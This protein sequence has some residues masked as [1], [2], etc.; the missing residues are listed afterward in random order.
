[1]PEGAATPDFEAVYNVILFYQKNPDFT[2]QCAL[3][4]N[5]VGQSVGRLRSAELM[6]PL[7][8]EPLESVH[9]IEGQTKGCVRFDEAE[10]AHPSTIGQGFGYEAKLDLDTDGD[11]SISGMLTS[12]TGIFKMRKVWED[13]FE[14]R[15]LFEGYWRIE[16]VF[17]VTLSFGK[18]LVLA[19]PFWAVRALR[20]QGEEVG[21]DAGHGNYVPSP[22][23]SN[24]G[25]LDFLEGLRGGLEPVSTDADSALKRLSGID[26]LFGR[27]AG[28]SGRL[29]F[30]STMNIDGL[31]AIHSLATDPDRLPIGP[32]VGDLA[33]DPLFGSLSD[34]ALDA[35]GILP[36]TGSSVD[37][38]HAKKQLSE[39]SAGFDSLHAEIAA[40]DALRRA[41]PRAAGG[42]G[43]AAGTPLEKLDADRPA[44]DPD[45]GR[46]GIGDIHPM[47]GHTF[48]SLKNGGL[49]GSGVNTTSL[50]DNT[51]T[52]DELDID[53]DL[54]ALEASLSARRTGLSPGSVLDGRFSGIHAVPGSVEAGIDVDTAALSHLGGGDF[55]D[56]GEFDA[57][58]AGMNGGS[59]D[60]KLAEM[61]EKLE[62][63]GG[64]MAHLSKLDPGELDTL[65]EQ[66]HE[67]NLDEKGM[68]ALLRKL[69]GLSAP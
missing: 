6:H 47:P 37:D 55:L 31:G 33:S 63:N 21:I 4:T 52:P 41:E 42:P 16:V 69:D 50:T 20:K 40:R 27:L 38:E 45:L 53:A 19:F 14:G 46:L 26:G 18:S 56:D 35:Y 34:S 36:M 30:S 62:E 17:S 10:S 49:S 7:S 60:C 8:R 15:E 3:R 11:V 48:R 61:I 68:N 22:P 23:G 39:A 29:G 25:F 5:P 67:P 54:E 1:L 13:Q 65:V 59:G 51:K 66:L 32:N 12:G 9:V 58:L 28:V 43:A 2:F 64:L 24:M 44:L 57:L